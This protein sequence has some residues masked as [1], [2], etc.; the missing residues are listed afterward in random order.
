MT[1][2]HPLQ[3]LP[4][5]ESFTLGTLG[6]NTGLIANNSSLVQNFKS[7]SIHESWGLNGLAAGDGPILY[8]IQDGELTLAELEEYLEA[9]ITDERDTPQAEQVQR[10]IQVLG[11]LG[12]RQETVFIRQKSILPTFRENRGF[13]HWIY[14]HGPAM[15]TGALV[16]VKGRFFGR[17]LS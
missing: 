16:F 7:V 5:A 1:D 4:T 13:T 8:G 12:L 17:W 11:S 15:T 3:Q 2:R 10:P 14:N 9:A 6:N